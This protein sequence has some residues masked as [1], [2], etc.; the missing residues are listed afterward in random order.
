MKKEIGCI[1]YLLL[2]VILFV[3]KI[4]TLLSLSWGWVLMPVWLPLSI[5]NISALVKLLIEEQIKNRNKK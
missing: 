3:L 2:F 1:V 4:T 5:F